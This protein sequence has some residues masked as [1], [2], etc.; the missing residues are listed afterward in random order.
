[1]G[2]HGYLH[3]DCPPQKLV[4]L[5]QSAKPEPVLLWLLMFGAANQRGASVIAPGQG[6][7]SRWAERSFSLCPYGTV[8]SFYYGGDMHHHYRIVMYCQIVGS[9]ISVTNRQF[10]YEHIFILAHP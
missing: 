6:C 1:M 3:S 9:C 4:L 7:I 2:G 5:W 8:F 10:L